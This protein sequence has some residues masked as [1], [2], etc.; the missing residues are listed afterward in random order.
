[1]IV[2]KNESI[3]DKKLQKEKKA[4]FRIYNSEKFNHHCE[5]VTN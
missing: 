1:M 4:Q 3:K 2:I 5:Y